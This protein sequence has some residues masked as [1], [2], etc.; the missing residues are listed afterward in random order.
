M[1]HA[2]LLDY[3]DEVARYGS[4]R[5]AGSRLHVSPSAIN[6]QILL[7]EEELGEPIFERLPRG[8]RPTPAGEVLLAHVR[9]T[10]Q[11]YR[12]AVADIHALRSLPTGEVVIDTVTGLASSIVSTAAVRFHAR[13]PEVQISVQTMPGQDTLEEVTGSSADLGLGFNLRLSAQVEIVWQRDARLGAVLSPRHPLAPM[14]AI[15]LADCTR[16]PLVFP[17]RP[18]VIHAII[19][20][21]FAAA[22]IEAEP[23]FRTNS[24]ETMKRMASA[25][26]VIAF[27]SRYDVPEEQ[28]DGSLEYRPISE[29][30]FGDNVLSLVR[31]ARTGHDLASRLFAAELAATLESVVA[32]PAS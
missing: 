21:A 8:M 6:R 24:I 30:V 4:I 16:Y 23:A 28:S 15:P 32:H 9:G 31:R 10:L 29:R 19:E 27:L 22:G 1:L 11:Q 20:D 5:A 3:L 25:G 18:M 12:E 26:D 13:H 17:N 14:K 2:R 7:L